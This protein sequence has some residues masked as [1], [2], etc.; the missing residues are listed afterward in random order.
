MV[1][2]L[3][4]VGVG[5]LVEVGVVVVLTTL[6]CVSVSTSSIVGVEHAEIRK[7]KSTTRIDFFTINL[8]PGFLSSSKE[9]SFEYYWLYTSLKTSLFIA[10]T[11][12]N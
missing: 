1:G 8:S 5:V 11:I 3:V 12:L 9:Y 7:V 10:Y 2:V 4:P 6:V